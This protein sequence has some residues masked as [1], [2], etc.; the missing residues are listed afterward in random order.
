VSA[1]ASLRVALALALAAGSGCMTIDTQT[2]EGYEGPQVYSGTRRDLSIIP[3]ALLNFSVGGLLIGVVDLPF[4]LL[5][6]T[7]ILPVTIPKDAERTRKLEEEKRVDEERP[8]VV[9]PQAGEAPVATAHR[10]FTEC[11]RM[12]KEQDSHFSDCYSID[13]KIEIVGSEPMRGA[14][15]K[16]L[17]RESLSQE[18]SEGEMI[19]WRDP[20]FSA[21]GERVRISAKRARSDDPSRV[22]VSLIVGPGQDGGWR[23]LEEVG[24]GF[25]R[26]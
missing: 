22:P 20:E 23:I 4:S 15:Y 12:L 10:L 17:A 19:E 7:V 11:A 24:P 2:N 16:K 26:K 21:D 3:N 1:K 14:D 13:A 9:K 25:N 18:A 5:A 8:S 6:D